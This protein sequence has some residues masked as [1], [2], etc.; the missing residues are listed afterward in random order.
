MDACHVHHAFMSP[1]K[2]RHLRTKKCFPICDLARYPV[3]FSCRCNFNTCKH[4]HASDHASHGMR[5][6]RMQR[7]YH[8]PHLTQQWEFDRANSSSDHRSELEQLSNFP[9][10]GAGKA[11][12]KV[13]CFCCRMRR[14]SG[15]RG[16][17]LREQPLAKHSCAGLP[18]P[19]LQS[20]GLFTVI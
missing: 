1:C 14:L 5:A 4:T 8:T 3:Q 20:V 11:Y 12:L 10:G 19:P 16:R 7:M 15:D 18:R 6:Q 17:W 13:A 9:A 2:Q